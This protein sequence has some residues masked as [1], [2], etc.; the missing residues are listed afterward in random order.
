MVTFPAKEWNQYF[1]STK[2]IWD[3]CTNKYAIKIIPRDKDPQKLMVA[4]RVR[5]FIIYVTLMLWSCLQ[6]PTSSLFLSLNQLNLVHI[7]KLLLVKPHF[8][9][10]FLLKLIFFKFVT[11]HHFH[12]Q[13]PQVFSSL[14]CVLDV[15]SFSGSLIVSSY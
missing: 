9:I 8:N 7:L 13:F 1:S 4:Q 6:K 12:H 14:P 15:R 2:E 5:I 11:S 3:V 10:I